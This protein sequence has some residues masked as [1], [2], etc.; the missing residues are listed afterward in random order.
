M[1]ADKLFSVV[2]SLCFGEDSDKDQYPQFLNMANIVIA[3]LFDINNRLRLQAGKDELL[4]IPQLSAL[5]DEL[6]YE[7]R[8]IMT[9]IPYGVAGMLYA[10]DDDTGMG[11]YYRGKYEQQKGAYTVARFSEAEVD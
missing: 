4:E 9:V 7:P 6:N 2:M 10:E 11:D 1:T 8:L 5:T 3:E